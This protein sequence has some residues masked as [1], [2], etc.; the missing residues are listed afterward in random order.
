MHENTYFYWQKKLR[1][2]A[3]EQLNVPSFVEVRLATTEPAPAPT[4]AENSGGLRIE[5][6]GVKIAV[7]SAYPAE[8]LVVL[9]RA[10]SQS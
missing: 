9:L 10:L 5:A 8:K 7:D 2:A 4:D 6:G 3:C 1:K